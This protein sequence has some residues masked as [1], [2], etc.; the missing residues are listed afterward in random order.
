MNKIPIDRILIIAIISLIFLVSIYYFKLLIPFFA[1]AFVAYLLNPIVTK[2]EKKKIN[3]NLGSLITILALLVFIIVFSFS[4]LPMVV[5]QTVIF[6]ERFPNLIERAESY[7][8]D[9]SILLKKYSI[10]FDHISLLKDFHNSLGIILKLIIN[11]FFFSSLAIIN[12]VSF[13][14]LTPIVSWYFLKDWH[15]IKLFF[16][17]NIPGKYQKNVTNNLN[18]IDSIVSSFIRGQVLVSIILGTYY[19]IFF[20]LIGAE[21]SILLGFLSGIFSLIPY[22]GIIVSFILSS[23]IIVLQFADINYFLYVSLIFI[24]SFLL[25][26]YILA[27]KII[28]QK[29]GLHPL[30]ILYSV[31]IFGSLLGIVG[32][33]FSIP[34]SCIIYLYYKKIL[35]NLNKEKN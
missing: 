9:L 20:F 19:F 32:V 1:G 26:G 2:A 7:F 24:G 25:E 15:K 13:L 27:P 22:I 35:L 4:I 12:I 10:D 8:S 21:Y 18:E 3:R 6:L 14:F 30:I 29:L 16:I 11:K 31:F 17:N 33:F 34:F 23:Y 28:G 5:K